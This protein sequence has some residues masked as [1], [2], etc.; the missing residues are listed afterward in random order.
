M[1]NAIK[2]NPSMGTIPIPQFKMIPLSKLNVS[3]LVA[4]GPRKISDLILS[5]RTFYF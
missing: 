4:N 5:L 3:I 2:K 1:Q